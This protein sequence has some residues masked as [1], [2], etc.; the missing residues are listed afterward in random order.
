M[1]FG[2]DPLSANTLQ[3]SVGRAKANGCI[4]NT[5]IYRQLR[6]GGWVANF[7][8]EVGVR[9]WGLLLD[10]ATAHPQT[11]LRIPVASWGGRGGDIPH[12]PVIWVKNSPER[13]K[14]P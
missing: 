5:H 9:A 4:C 6:R 10:T 2:V 11:S 14:S 7:G 13:L 3:C 1:A 12:P 8:S